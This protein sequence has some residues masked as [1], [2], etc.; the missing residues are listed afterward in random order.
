M[1]NANGR[2]V[3][4]WDPPE[5]ITGPG[6]PLRRTLGGSALPYVL[7]ARVANSFLGDAGALH[8]ER[9]DPDQTLAVSAWRLKNGNVRIL[10][11]NVEEE[12]A[13]RCRPE[14]AGYPRVAWG[15]EGYPI[16]ALK[17]GLSHGTAR[18]V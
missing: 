1:D 3:S 8:A 13:G 4:F 5:F 14:P 17:T 6:G 16:N 12:L 18:T 11:G 10:G 9:I 2:H 15:F 7:T